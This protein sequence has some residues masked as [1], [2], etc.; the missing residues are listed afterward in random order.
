MAKV[1]RLTES[2][3]VRLVKKVIEEQS[4]S[5]NTNKQKS[6]FMTWLDN[7][8]QIRGTGVVINAIEECLKKNGYSNYDSAPEEFKSIILRTEGFAYGKKFDGDSIGRVDVRTKKLLDC[9]KQND[10]SGFFKKSSE[11]EKAW[12]FVTSK[13]F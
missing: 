5:I 3:L 1:V 6:P 10:Y 8:R 7:N 12:N 9:M 13:L 11:F 2:D 4:Q